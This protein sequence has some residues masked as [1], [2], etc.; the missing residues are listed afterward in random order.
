VSFLI[1][2]LLPIYDNDGHPF[3][4]SESQQV[5]RELT[6]RFGGVTAYTRAPAEGLWEDAEGRTKRDD[7]VVFEVMAEELD[8]SWWNAYAEELARRFEQE[9]LVVRAISFESLSAKK[10]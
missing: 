1:Q 2:L 9:E 3:P 7:V 4:H 10:A 8:R 6:D 5:R